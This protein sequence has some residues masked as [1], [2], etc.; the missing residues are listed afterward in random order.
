M[1]K[2]SKIER[3]ARREEKETV[4]RI[5][6]LSLF[7]LILAVFLFI[8]GIRILAKFS[9]FLGT[10]FKGKD[11]AL[12]QQVDVRTPVLDP[13]PHATNSAKLAVSGFADDESKILIFKN[14]VQVGEAQ[15][16]DGKFKYGSVDLDRGET[17]V[18]AKATKSNSESNFSDEATV[19]LSTM[20]PKL[21]VETP[22]DGQS[23]SGNNRIKVAGS[24]DKDAQVYA[25]GFLAMVN[26]DGRFEVLVPILEG[27]TT[28]EIKAV[29]EAGNIKV[30]NRKVSFHK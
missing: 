8:F 26:S 23:Y 19:I 21:D 20:E 22:F 24:T 28:L 27:E 18:K 30:A 10:I 25:N 7:S 11:N 6:Y 16:S 13:L 29:N 9:D 14:G 12:S 3:L 15:V 4:K 17:K 1:R 5:F 2:T